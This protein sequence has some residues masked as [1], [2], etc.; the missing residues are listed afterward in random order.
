MGGYG[1]GGHSRTHD[2]TGRYKQLDSFY[3]GKAALFMAKKGLDMFEHP[4]S[5]TDGGKIRIVLF[6]DK[7]VAGYTVGSESGRE[8]IADTFYF[9]SVPNNY[10][11]EKVYF[12]CPYCDRRSRFLYLHRRHFKSRLCARLNYCSQQMSKG[13]DL[14][15]LGMQRALKKLG[16]K[17]DFAPIDMECY[18][19]PKPKGMHYKTYFKLLEELRDAQD[20]Y[21]YNW[22]IVAMRI[23]G[24]S[25]DDLRQGKQL[26]I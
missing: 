20:E 26:F 16:I 7:L 13:V 9:E 10:G 12:R 19:P 25:M 21:H 24:I 3:F 1:S 6:P 17:D 11:G 15:I 5:W 14:S 8:E 22:T 4:V 23:C 18:T 2:Y